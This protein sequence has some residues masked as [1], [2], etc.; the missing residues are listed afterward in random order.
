MAKIRWA[1]IGIVRGR[2]RPR[3]FPVCANHIQEYHKRQGILPGKCRY[4]RGGM[5]PL[6]TK[7]LAV[8]AV[9]PTSGKQSSGNTSQGFVYISANMR[10]K[11]A[12]RNGFFTAKCRMAL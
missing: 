3:F 11:V 5:L 2:F 8:A 4:R 1:R 12:E 10:H 6:R 7:V 9:S